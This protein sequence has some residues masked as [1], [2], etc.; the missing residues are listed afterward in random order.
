MLDEALEL[1]D[2]DPNLPLLGAIEPPEVP[3]EHTISLHALT[4]IYSS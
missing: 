4:S 3:K 1:E 2:I